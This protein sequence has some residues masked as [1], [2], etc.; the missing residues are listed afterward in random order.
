M[1]RLA[2]SKNTSATDSSFDLLSR[3]AVDSRSDER[4]PDGTVLVPAD[5]PDT[6]RVLSRAIDERRP[7]ALVFPDGSDVVARPPEADG[8]TLAIV[9]SLMRLADLVGRK[10]DRP[11]FVPREW[12]M[13]F[14]AAP[15]G[16]KPDS[17]AEPHRSP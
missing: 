10:R 4:Y 14:H 17:P 7:I 11:T 3:I 8:V 1:E 16:E 13:E 12:V 2:H 9:A 6:S 5:S 15:P